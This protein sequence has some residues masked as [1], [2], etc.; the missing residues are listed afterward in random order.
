MISPKCPKL[1]P[2]PAPASKKM[3]WEFWINYDL[4][5]RSVVAHKVGRVNHCHLH[6]RLAKFRGL[7]RRVK[8][9][10]VIGW[11]GTH[12][13]VIHTGHIQK[14][15]FSDQSQRRI[16][17][18]S[19]NHGIS[20]NDSVND[21]GWPLPM[22]G[23]AEIDISDA[24]ADPHETFRWLIKPALSCLFTGNL[25]NSRGVSRSGI[26]SLWLFT[27]RPSFSQNM[28]TDERQ[29]SD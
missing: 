5:A 15:A 2:A 14:N 19:S 9:G 25:T 4:Q 10:A 16:S 28:H 29:S 6:C 18:S 11:R 13:L 20:P 12:S 27:P 23:T 8:Y 26:K 22:K 17:P 1:A 24:I 21:S 7:M 3:G